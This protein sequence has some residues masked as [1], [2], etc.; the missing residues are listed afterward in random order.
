MQRHESC[1]WG[2]SLPG[3]VPIAEDTERSQNAPRMSLPLDVH[4]ENTTME[5]VYSKIL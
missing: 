5:K 4:R 3:P 1:R 2:L